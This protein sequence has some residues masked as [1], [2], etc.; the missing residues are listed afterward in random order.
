MVAKT[1]NIAIQRLQ[2]KLHAFCC[3]FYRTLSKLTA[4]KYLDFEDHYLLNLHLPNTNS[5]LLPALRRYTFTYTVKPRFTDI[6][7]IR[8][9]R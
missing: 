5:S 6:R 7:L 4:E 2:D 9:L 3:P 8:T 1:R